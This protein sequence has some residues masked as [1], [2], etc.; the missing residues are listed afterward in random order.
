MDLPIAGQIENTVQAV[1]H[2]V[3]TLPDDL[4]V[5]GLGCAPQTAEGVNLA[6][7]KIEPAIAGESLL[8]NISITNEVPELRRLRREIENTLADTPA[9]DIIMSVCLAVDEATQNIIRHAFPTDTS[10]TIQVSG[11]IADNLLYI[12]LVDD[13][14]LIDLDKVRP[15]DLD[16]L[17]EGGLGTHFIMEITEQAN[18][19]HRDGRNRLD[20][21]FKI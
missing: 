2:K 14:P 16:D 10:G 8:F 6:S 4:T 12:S 11:Y 5:L 18:W 19:S 20:L 3:E 21:A 13:A 1:R 15:R 7:T 17:R 9:R